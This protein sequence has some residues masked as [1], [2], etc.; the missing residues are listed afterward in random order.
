M[1]T[2]AWESRTHTA[3]DGYVW[4]YRFYPAR[5]TPRARLVY[6]HGIQSH[7]GWYEGSST[8]LAQEGFEVYFLDRRGS[9]VNTVARGDTPSFL[10]LV[11][12][13]GEFVKTLPTDRPKVLLGISWAGK[14]C[15]ALQRRHPGL[16]QGQCLLCPGLIPKIAPSPLMQMR[17]AG[18]SLV[19]PSRLFPIPLSDPELFTR[20]PRWLEYLRQDPLALHNATARFL[21]QSFW[22][23]RY[24]RGC[25]RHVTVPTLLILAGKD[26]IINN[27]KTTR[28]CEQFAGPLEVRTY[29][30]AH[31]T[32]EFE[33]DGPPF[34]EDLLWWLERRGMA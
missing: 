4:G 17:I 21:V 25:P 27:F 34:V 8:R 7:G 19:T 20:T 1:N 31:H 23:D 32:L 18:A 2:P 3:S 26:A 15:V 16:V 12:D 30:E 29:P 33:P 28:Y 11:D 14:L 22:L 10:R 5:G 9:G 24:L 13:L 6:L